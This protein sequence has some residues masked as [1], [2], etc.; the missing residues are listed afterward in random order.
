[1]SLKRTLSKSRE[2]PTLLGITDDLSL[3]LSTRLTEG[4]YLMTPR[5]RHEAQVRAWK[6]KARKQTIKRRNMSPKVNFH[7]GTGFQDDELRLIRGFIDVEQKNT[8]G[9]CDRVLVWSLPA[10][11]ISTIE[12][13]SFDWLENSLMLGKRIPEDPY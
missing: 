2:N 8:R 5:A 13:A 1:M 11:C 9:R 12:I 7:V 6:R 3:M 4:L 10:I